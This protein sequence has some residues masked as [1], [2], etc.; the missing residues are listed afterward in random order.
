MPPARRRR[1]PR[2]ASPHRRR[3]PL[4][5]SAHLLRAGVGARPHRRSST[6]PSRSRTPPSASAPTSS[7]SPPPPRTLLA[8]VRRRHRRRPP[9]RHAARHPR[10]GPRSP[11]RC[12][13][14]CGST[15]RC[16]PTSPRSPAAACTSSGPTTGHLAGGD[17]GP[18]RLADPDAI[19]AAA[20]AVLA[21]ARD[22]AGRC[23]CSS[24]RAAPA[25]RSTRSG[26]SATGRRGRWGTPSPTPRA[27]RR[28]ARHPRDHRRP[29]RR[30]RASTSIRGRRP[31][32][33]WPT[34]SLDRFDAADA[35][36]MAAAVADFR[37]KAAA[38][39]KLKKGDGVPELLLEPTPDILATL[40]ERADHQVLVGFAAETDR[41]AEHAAAKL[42]AKSLDL[43]VAND[44]S[45]A[46][47]RLRGRHE[48]GDPAG[49]DGSTEELPLLPK[50]VL[51]G[52]RPG[53]RAAPARPQD[54]KR[55]IRDRPLHVHLRVGDGGP[56]RQD[57][58]PDQR[59]RPRRHLRRGP[60]EPCRV[61]EHGH[62]RPRASS[63]ARSAPTPTSTSPGS[64]A[65]PSAASATTASRTA[66]TATPA[67]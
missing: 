55:G 57:V 36:I 42:A 39:E 61:R 13:P 2:R 3:T 12:T 56:P 38:P 49:L 44:V 51:A 17:D 5:R 60:R 25:S 24:P 6:G 18:G 7:S 58:R 59:R 10:P 66:S 11:R 20:A 21:A 45:A 46:R 52:D 64:C 8:Q 63:P 31:P 41:L 47:R 65:T 22:L 1:R 62:H 33:R 67:A 32:R 27:A 29:A 9:H 30:V 4:R 54:H 28:R 48:P 23:A 53:P 15:P 50:T 14:R 34:P 16:R 35:V 40:G 37:P 43:V 19:V 26:S